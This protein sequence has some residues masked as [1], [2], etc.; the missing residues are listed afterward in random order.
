MSLFCLVHGSTQSAACW[1]LLIPKLERRG[2]DV[3]RMNLPTD[4]P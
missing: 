3:V 2:H 1:D 4:E